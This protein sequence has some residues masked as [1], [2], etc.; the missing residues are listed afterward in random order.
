[1][2]KFQT[3][4]KTRLVTSYSPIEISGDC[5]YDAQGRLIQYV[6]KSKD[7]YWNNELGWVE[8][9]K[10]ATHFKEPEIKNLNLPIGR[11]VRWLKV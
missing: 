4:N 9:S 8:K 1:M 2:Y 10:D 6:I 5:L 3:K 7:G 11:E